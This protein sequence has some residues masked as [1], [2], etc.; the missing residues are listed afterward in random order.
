MYGV[1][2]RSARQDFIPCAKSYTWIL[3]D[4]PRNN[5]NIKEKKK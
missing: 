5:F 3:K 1:G 4:K 2:L